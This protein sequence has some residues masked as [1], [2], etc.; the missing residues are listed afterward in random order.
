M[1]TI[2]RMYCKNGSRLSEEIQ[3]LREERD[4]LLRI[5]MQLA[6]RMNRKAGVNPPSI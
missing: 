3:R 2:R 4:A 6:L 5:L 1:P